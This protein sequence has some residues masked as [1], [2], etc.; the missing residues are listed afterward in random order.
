MAQESFL[1]R[2]NSRFIGISAFKCHFMWRADVLTGGRSFSYQFMCVIATHP[3]F[4]CMR[5]R[6]TC[7]L[8]L[9]LLFSAL[10]VAQR[11]LFSA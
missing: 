8:P 9:L 7:V 3:D 2:L 4:L 5:R 11:V 10:T 6:G 1:K